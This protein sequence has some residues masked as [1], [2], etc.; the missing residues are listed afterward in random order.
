MILREIQ[1]QLSTLATHFPA[2]TLTGPRQSGK[3]T[4]CRAVF[5]RQ[6]YASL[7]DPDVRRF[8]TDDPRAFLAQFP[9]GAIL[10][11]FQRCPDLASYLQGVIDRDPRPGKWIL[12]G[13]H[14]LDLMQTV[15]QSLAGR[16]GIL[17]LLP[18]NRREVTRFSPCPTELDEAIFTGGYPRILDRRIPVA[19]WLASYV[20]TY[21]E[22]DVRT[23]LKVGDLA[24]FQRFLGLC[25]G[26][27]A[28]L[29]NLSNLAAD[30][31]ITQPT[32]KAWFSVLEASFLVFRLPAYHASLNKR[33]VKMPKLHFYDTGLAC[34]LLGIRE[35]GQLRQ[36]P[37]RGPIFESWVASEVLKQ[38]WCAGQTGG[39]F[40]YRDQHGTEADLLVS[41]S[42]G[43]Q[44]VEVKV[45]ATPAADMLDGAR[46]V[47]AILG[48][49]KPPVAAVIEPLVVYGGD[50]TQQRAQ[51]T[52]LA[53][54]DI[55]NR[56]WLA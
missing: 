30:C 24:A 27:T 48:Q 35:P 40:Y 34:W 39:V 16:T 33:L 14:N 55:Q 5:P 10:D 47:T 32:A 52:F 53:W 50:T 38:R 28:Q 22:R 41:A 31:G 25:A 17:H 37:L 4:L 3:S 44:V 23:F 19:T 54:A 51:G 20:A 9:G 36:H 2:V 45:G 12:T 8:A 42:G 15:S 26:R 11:E 7:E 6:P 43:L 49:A 29:L 1:A 46:R 18:L 21:L 13:S 56:N